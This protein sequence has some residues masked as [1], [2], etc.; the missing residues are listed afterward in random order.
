MEN[1]DSLDSEVM[2]SLRDV[3]VSYG[4]VEILHG[5][6]FD[7]KRGE[8][9]VILGGSGSGQKHSSAD[10]GRPGKSELR[11]NLDQRQK[12]RGDFQFGNGRDSQE[13]RHVVS[14]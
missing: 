13:D 14:R 3:R 12:H 5:I 1:T 6:T 7:V 8:T 2:V 9:L 10:T 11:R 4:D